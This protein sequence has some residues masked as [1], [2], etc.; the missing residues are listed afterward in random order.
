MEAK[1]KIGEKVRI[2][3]HSDKSMINNEVEIINVH[4]SN[5]SPHKGYVDEWLYNVWDGKKSL[6]WA[7]E[8]DLEPLQL[9]S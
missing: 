1:F 6:G 2:A 9:P 4:H 3:N 5:F 8:C 7:P